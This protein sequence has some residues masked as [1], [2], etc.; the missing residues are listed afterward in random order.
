M[1]NVYVSNFNLNLNCKNDFLSETMPY[2]REPEF[3]E[4]SPKALIPAFRIGD[5]GFCESLIVV[6]F[7]DEYFDGPKLLSGDCIDRAQQRQIV[8]HGNSFKDC[9]NLI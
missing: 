3:V 1:R 8:D 6:E 9:F 2:K 4:I 7:I 5:R